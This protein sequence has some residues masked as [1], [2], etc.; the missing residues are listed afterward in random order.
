[1]NKNN[2]GWSWFDPIQCWEALYK[3]WKECGVKSNC[4]K[5]AT[6]EKEGKVGHKSRLGQDE[7][8]DT[9]WPSFLC[10]KELRLYF[11]QRNGGSDS[12]RGN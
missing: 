12:Q 1:M 4:I 5:A 9:F 2:M 11:Q 7:E 6:A 10:N 3:L 8:E